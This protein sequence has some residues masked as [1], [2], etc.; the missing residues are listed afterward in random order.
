MI[1]TSGKT[2]R[3]LWEEMDCR[4]H[5]YVYRDKVWRYVY[6]IKFENMVKEINDVKK[7]H[8]NNIL[9]FT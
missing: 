2:E 4:N 1:Y 5:A 9:L 3:K 8:Y 7:R 6:S